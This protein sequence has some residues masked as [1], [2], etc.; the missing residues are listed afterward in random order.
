MLPHPPH[1]CI[2]RPSGARRCS[3]AVVTKAVVTRWFAAGGSAPT[4]TAQGA[5][6]PCSGRHGKWRFRR[7]IPTAGGPNDP[8]PDRSWRFPDLSDWRDSRI[9][10]VGRGR[11]TVSATPMPRRCFA[12]RHAGSRRCMM[13]HT[14]P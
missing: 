11:R 2:S 8:Q 7:P 6:Q 10:K 12:G 9:C 4:R 5:I 13:S 14:R 1:R 3:K